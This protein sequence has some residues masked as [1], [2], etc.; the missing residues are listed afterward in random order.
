MSDDLA[1][2][3]VKTLKTKKRKRKPCFTSDL[4]TTDKVHPCF[5]KR[6]FACYLFIFGPI[7]ALGRGEY[8]GQILLNEHLL[9]FKTQI[10]QKLNK[11]A[12]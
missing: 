12:R 4:P 1:M 9:P 8:E 7:C 2:F 3:A 10:N 6:T 5:A 11:M